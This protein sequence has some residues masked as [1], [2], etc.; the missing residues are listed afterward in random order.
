MLRKILFT[1]L[2]GGF[3]II[4]SACASESPKQV[5]AAP[6]N[7]PIAVFPNQIAIV[8]QGNM[9]LK[10]ADVDSA[11]IQLERMAGKYGGYLAGTQSWWIDG[12]KIT[13]LELFVPT[14]NFESL[15]NAVRGLGS[16]VSESISSVVVSDKP[17][18]HFS[19]LTV[20]LRSGGSLP[21]PPIHSGWDPL[22]TVQRAWQVFLTIFGFLADIL[23]WVVIVGGPFVLIALGIRVLLRRL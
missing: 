17:S 16:L 23:I 14:A 8:Y 6:K 7:S 15:C 5:A 10:V 21:T 4:F 2:I 1:I 12:R 18:S 13:I 20:Q 11:S 19:S 9:E 22:R 3:I